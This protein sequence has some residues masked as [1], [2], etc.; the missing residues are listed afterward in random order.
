MK[1]PR[2]TPV[3][4]NERFEKRRKIVGHGR[5][6]RNSGIDALAIQDK[7]QPCLGLGAKTE[8]SLRP[9]TGPWDYARE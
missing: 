5:R 7:L 9:G 1:T 6:L 8:Y 4:F 3:V 2:A